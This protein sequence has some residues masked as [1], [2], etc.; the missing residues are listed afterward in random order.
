MPRHAVFIAD[1]EIDEL[2]GARREPVWA[3]SDAV[4]AAL[5]G[6]DVAPRTVAMRPSAATEAA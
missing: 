6:D 5:V 4:L 2:P 3:L 1:E